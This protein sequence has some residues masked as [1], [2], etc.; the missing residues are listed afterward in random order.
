MDKRSEIDDWR[1]PLGLNTVYKPTNQTT[2]DLI[3][4]HGLAGGSRKTWTRKQDPALFWPQ[5]LPQD[6]AFKDV[7]VHMFGYDSNWSNASILNIQDFA[8]SLLEWV[9]NSP[10]IPN[11]ADAPLI[12][13]CHSMGGLVAKQAYIL[14]RRNERYQKFSRRLRSVF[15]LATPHRG[16]DLAGLLSRILLVSGSRPFVNDL[17]PNSAAIQA[18]NDEFP[19]YSKDLNLWSFW[20]TLPMT[21]GFHKKMVVPRESAILGYSNERSMYL[22][23]DH[24][25][26]SLSGFGPVMD[27][28]S[29]SISLEQR[30]LIDDSLDISNSPEDDYLRVDTLRVPGTCEWIN[31]RPE[32]Q[33]WRNEGQPKLYWLT[34]KPGAGKSVLSGYVVKS[35]REANKICEFFF[36]NHGDKAKSTITIFF[37]CMAWQMASANT[38]LLESLSKTCKK[39]PHLAQADHTTM[40]RKLFLECIFK[41]PPSQPQYWVV[42]ALDECKADNELI[43]YLFQAANTGFIRIFL[44]SRSSFYSYGLPLTSSVMV[45]TDVVSQ[46]TID[47]DIGQYLKVN[48]NRLPGPDRGLTAGLVL[49]KASGCFLWARLVLQELRRVSTRTGIQQILEEVPSD[50]SQLYHRILDSIFS[51]AREKRMIRAIL[52]WT[53]CASRPLTTTELYHALRLDMEEEIDDDVKMFI[54]N[55]CG[56][57]VVVDLDDRVR[58]IHLTARDFLFSDENIS[59]ARLD[60]KT[61]H[62][63]LA[64]VSLK[65]LCGPEMGVPKQ[66]KLSATRI[67]LERCPFVAYA[68]DALCQHLPSIASDDDEFAASLVCFLKTPNVLSWIEYIARGSDLRPLVQTGI[69]LHQFTKRRATQTPSTGNRGEEIDLIDTWATDIIRLV[70]RF[71]TKL[72]SSPSVVFNLLAPFC[73][74]DSAMRIQHGSST[75][76][77]RV[78]GLSEQTW[79]YCMSTISLRASPTAVACGTTAFAVGMRNGDIAIFDATTCQELKTVNHGGWV[80]KL[81]FG[82]TGNLLVSAGLKHIC[83]WNS[84]TWKLLW[85]FELHNQ[86]ISLGLADEDQLLLVTYRS[87][88]IVMWEI[89]KG[90]A[91]EPISWLNENEQEGAS[92]FLRPYTTAISGDRTLLAFTYRG[93]DIVLWDIENA[94]V[95]DVYGK[96]EGSL[97]ATADKRIG[98]SPVQSMIFSR[99]PE[100]QLLVASYNDGELNLFNIA[101]GTVQAKVVANGHYLTSSADGLTLACGN[102]AG[103]ICIFEFSTLN[104]LYRIQTKESIIKQLAFSADGHRLLDIQGNHCRIWDPPVLLHQRIDG[105][106]YIDPVDIRLDGESDVVLISAMTCADNGGLI[107]CGKEDGGVYLYD[108]QTGLEREELFHRHASILYLQ[109]DV[110]SSILFCCDMVNRVTVHKLVRTGDLWTLGDQYL[111]HRTGVEVKQILPNTGGSRL[112]ISTVEYDI[113]WEVTPAQCQEV[114]WLNWEDDGKPRRWGMHPSRSDQ[115]ILMTGT[116][117]HLYEWDS[118]ERLTGDS[119]TRFP[120]LDGLELLIKGSRPVFDEKYLATTF[121]DTSG[122]HARSRLVFWNAEDITPGNGLMA[123]IEHFQPLADQVQYLVG[124]HNRRVVFLHVDG[125]ICS[126][127]SHNFYEEYYDRHFFIPGDW[128]IA[129]KTLQIEVLR[130]GTILFVKQDELAVIKRGLEYF[131]HGQSRARAKHPT[132]TRP[133]ITSPTDPASRAVSL[134][135]R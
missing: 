28:S 14:S 81:L 63:R 8:L 119:G 72:H 87:N 133:A 15:F 49:T 36:F 2:A 33:T 16:S 1:G 67:A 125:W 57:L 3:F 56:Q 88:E 45:H 114:V 42:D 59:V 51:R 70:T 123:P 46:E 66:N 71:G 44:T 110:Q 30:Q 27:L 31:S 54:E 47:V 122:P 61:G 26:I 124:I 76:S 53:A 13:L 69:A 89:A 55:N 105:Q 68:C 109:Y 62:K 52:N 75:R 6:P 132:I 7:G 5:W 126:A 40:W 102:S 29:N 95:Y 121:S 60:Q 90:H 103:V 120:E 17:R 32:F 48:I 23:A 91:R 9:T 65:Y 118:L 77:I 97:G 4:V 86:F 135:D 134:P 129:A 20:E 38:A 34:S 99:A 130:N 24:R 79:G 96:D 94:C 98:I 104:L 10:E 117:A 116:E 100:A 64:M 106:V 131:E 84:V 12:L 107:L 37:R 82:D 108:S 22:K 113:L 11:A 127:D 25:D 80:K 39:D 43:P 35:L 58:M 73:P 92:H 85:T 19:D 101:E 111:D 74:M 83:I 78:S 50:M 21:I 18:I 93:Q 115:L 128:L 112:L 41:H